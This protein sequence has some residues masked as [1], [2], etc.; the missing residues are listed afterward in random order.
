MRKVGRPIE[1]ENRKKIGL[2]ISGEANDT[3]EYLANLTGKT[4]SRI[5]EDSLR[6]MK[7][8]EEM[9]YARSKNIEKYGDDAFLDFEEY[10]KNREASKKE[11]E[12]RD[13]G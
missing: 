13:V 8:R 1:K 9:I 7:E 5:F 4:K 3:L 6:I 12:V 11:K 2:S 10:M